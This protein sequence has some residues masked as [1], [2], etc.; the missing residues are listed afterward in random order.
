MVASVTVA[1]TDIHLEKGSETWFLP[2]TIH[3]NSSRWIGDLHGTNSQASTAAL[4]GRS[5]WTPNI[6]AT[7]L[8]VAVEHLKRDW[9]D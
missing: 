6:I 3:K 9:C 4:S 2:H 7:W 1:G 8:R 5:F